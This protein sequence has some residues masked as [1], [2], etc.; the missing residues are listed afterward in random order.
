L[1]VSL[2]G[3][4][5]NRFG[6]GARVTA[7]AGGLR[8]IADVTTSGSIFSASDS[9]VHFGLGDADRADLEIL[10]PSG[11]SQSLPAVRAN[12]PLVVD[13]PQ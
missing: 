5:S 8:Q 3:R 10:W 9:R 4:T 12:Q 7:T 6:V 13:E 11:R 1:T 2:R